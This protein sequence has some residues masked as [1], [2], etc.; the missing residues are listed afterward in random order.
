MSPAALRDAIGPR[1]RAVI[2]VH[3]WGLPCDMDAIMEL[4]AERDLL[5]IEDAC[6]AVGGAYEGRML[7]SIGHVGAFSFNHY[8]NMSC[9]E[10]GAVVTGDDA[11]AERIECAIDPCRFY[12][13]GRKESFAGYLANGARASEIEGAIMNCQLDRIDEMIAAMRVQKSRILRETAACGLTPS[14][15]NSPDWEC[16]THVAFLLPTA[17]A[18]DTLAEKSG[19]WVALK[20]GRHVYTEW[21]PVL[22]TA[23][24]T[25]RR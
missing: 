22:G 17:A 14:P 20:T 24:P 7:G 4:A 21:D 1:T 13:D 11:F 9:G 18:A 23:A 5:V 16:G 15:A 8:K 6:Q 12:W 3:M 19:G 10:G 2:P 25:T